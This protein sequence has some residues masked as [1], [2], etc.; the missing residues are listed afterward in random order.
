MRGWAGWSINIKKV[1][2]ASPVRSTQ[3]QKTH[4]DR[5]CNRPTGA[6]HKY[7]GRDE[8]IGKK[9]RQDDLGSEVARKA[10]WKKIGLGRHQKAG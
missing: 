2:G 7:W 8:K 10:L 3:Q 9:D 1:V 5:W 4:D 6:L